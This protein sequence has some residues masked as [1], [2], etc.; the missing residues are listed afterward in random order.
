MTL[1]T[2]LDLHGLSLSPV[3]ERRIYAHLHRLERRLDK[4]PGPSA[5]V[6][7]RHHADQRRVEVDLRIELGPLGPTLV[8]H[9]AA[10][11]PDLATKRAVEDVERELERL[12]S[13]QRGEAAFGLPSRREPRSLRP[14][15]DR[16]SKRP[17]GGA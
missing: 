2:H 3:D 7:L 10:Q 9:Q 1:S 15:P 14:H 5:V 13:E 17:E 12:V 4:R 8:S 6:V 16:P 11:T